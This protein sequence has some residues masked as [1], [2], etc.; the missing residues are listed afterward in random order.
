[1]AKPL[2]T[3]VLKPNS[4]NQAAA[5]DK[6]GIILGENV[7]W[8]PAELPNGHVVLIGASGSGKT[9][10]LKSLAY[11]LPKLFPDVRR[12]I[13][14]FHGDQELPEEVCYPL[15][16]ESPHGINPLV[17][18][19]D[20]KGGGPNL[21]AIA[22]AATL[23]KSLTLGPN[24]EGLIIEIVNQCYATTGIVQDDPRTWTKKP[25]TFAD[26][27]RE[28]ENR[29]E[30]GCKESVKL[31]LKLAA[32]FQYGIF[33][34]P[35]PS[36]DAPLIRFDLSALGKVP[37]LAAIAAESLVKQLMDN[38]RIL[39]EVADKTP[40]TYTFIDESKEVKQSRSV[41]LVTGDGRK[42]GLCIVQASQRD[43]EI[44]EE[45]IA[46]S[47]TKIVLSV[48]QTEVSRVAKR[49]RFAENL[50]ANLQ[51]LEALVRMGTEGHR[52]KIKPYYERVS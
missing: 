29:V 8:N 10:T 40:R 32:T 33:S 20:T 39:G 5:K 23:K 21:Q 43:A 52:C 35:Q 49:F 30:D 9:Q 41:K 25:P 14:D 22:V 1:M 42:Y 46:N 4:K 36:L 12:V 28:I 13:I 2:P 50:V 31:Q 37:G 11:E 48:D 24:Q 51:P 17:V 19:L 27:Q 44:S 38:H 3:P 18:D 15:N 7:I 16:M 47:S 45:A 6:T 26:I 34:R